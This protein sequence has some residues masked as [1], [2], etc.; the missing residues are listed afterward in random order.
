MGEFGF[1]FAISIIT[2]SNYW[3]QKSLAQELWNTAYIKQP[4]K[5]SKLPGTLF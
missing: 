1:V 4:G 5:Y 3:I 2:N